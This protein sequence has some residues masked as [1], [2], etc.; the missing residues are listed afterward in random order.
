MARELLYP[1]RF[2]I[3]KFRN[4]AYEIIKAITIL[5]LLASLPII[6]NYPYYEKFAYDNLSHL[7]QESEHNLVIFNSYAN[8]STGVYQAGQ[9]YLLQVTPLRIWNGEIYGAMYVPIFII[10]SGGYRLQNFTIPHFWIISGNLSVEGTQ[11]NVGGAVQSFGSGTVLHTK[12]FWDCGLKVDV[13]VG[14]VVDG[15]PHVLGALNQKV[16]CW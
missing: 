11:E 10:D 7:P 3:L 5:I 16:V 2:S 12:V 8:S 14:I 13:Y 9:E 6:I 4:R 1:D 15:N